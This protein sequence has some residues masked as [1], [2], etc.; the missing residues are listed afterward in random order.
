MDISQT[1][2]VPIPMYR[3]PD[4][5][6]RLREVVDVDKMID[7]DN[8]MAK[9]MAD[10][11]IPF[12][13]RRLEDKDKNL[14]DR[15]NMLAKAVK[16]DEIPMFGVDVNK[17]YIIEEELRKNLPSEQR[18]LVDE[19]F[20]I[21]YMNNKDPETYTISFWSDY[22]KIAPAVVRNIVNYMAFP[23]MDDKTKKIK[24]ILFF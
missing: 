6:E 22:F 16:V 19:L 2:L 1:R 7:D 13:P 11:R 23:V 24:E 3:G 4:F 20:K 9:E 14:V 21:L 8:K 17:E 18:I 5:E 10:K 15:M 12:E